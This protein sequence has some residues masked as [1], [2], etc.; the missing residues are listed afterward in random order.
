MPSVA[1]AS[2]GPAHAGLCVGPRGI[3]QFLND[4]IAAAGPGSRIEA[5]AQVMVGVHKQ[6]QSAPGNNSPEGE[7][8]TLPV[9][10]VTAVV[11]SGTW[12]DRLEA[13]PAATEPEAAEGEAQ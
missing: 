4:L 10:L 9:L 3:E 6:E 13:T 5:L 7:H 11:R 8:S 2:A 1:P 12:I